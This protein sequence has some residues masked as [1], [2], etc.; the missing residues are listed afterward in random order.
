M[1]GQSVSEVSLSGQFFNRRE[2]DST[3]S[4]TKKC[5]SIISLCIHHLVGGIVTR[6]D[7]QLAID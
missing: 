3:S 6:L 5:G 1:V 7:L 4:Q 2:D